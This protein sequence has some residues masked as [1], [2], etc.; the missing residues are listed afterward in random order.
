MKFAE[1]ITKLV[2]N[3]PLI[4]LKKASEIT[5]CNILGKA[6]F[7][8]PGQSIKDR[9]ALRM[10][11]KLGSNTDPDS[12]V[13]VE[14]T[15]GNTGIGLTVIGNALG[16][17]TVIVM[18]N[19]QSIEKIRSL[20]FLGAEVILTDQ[21]PFDNPNNY[22]QLSK[23][24]AKERN[25]IWTNQ[26][27]NLANRE[28]HIYT[29][30]E[31]IWS[32]TQGKIDGFI[33]S[34]GTGG[35]LAGTYLGL[36]KKNRNIKIYCADPHGSGMYSWI[37][38]GNPKSSLSSITEGIGQSRITKNIQGIDFDG[39]FKISDQKA[40]DII[41]N[42]ILEEGLFLGPTSGINIA[43]AIKLAKKLGPNKT[44]VTV[45]CDYANRYT[46]KMFNKG[47]LKS[48]DINFPD[49]LSNVS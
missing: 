49:W 46:S 48:H 5:N 20:K 42:L 4:K 38:K 12:R 47:F 30:A 7:L 28:A 36:K 44:I 6:E 23:K 24:I 11:E 34:I 43:G 25:A 45:L 31:E 10:I 29:T 37:R 1:D 41:Y 27:D 17:R 22:I 9:A 32:Q 18:P 26:F 19:N 15:G 14:G 33:C 40:F 8:N 16:Y 3:T 35:T 13:I 2:G 21:V 39:A